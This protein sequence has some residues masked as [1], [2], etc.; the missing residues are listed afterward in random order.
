MAENRILV[1]RG[2]TQ[3]LAVAFNTSRE[4]IRRALSSEPANTALH[5][6]IRETALKPIDEGGYGGIEIVKVKI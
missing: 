5:Q 1:N 3:R 2:D 4:T 6:K